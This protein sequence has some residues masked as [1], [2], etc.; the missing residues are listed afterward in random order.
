MKRVTAIITTIA[1]LAALTGCNNG[2]IPGGAPENSTGNSATESTD[3]SESAPESTDNSESAPESSVPEENKGE[4]TFLTCVDGT[5]VY[6][7]DV[8][9]LFSSLVDITPSE[10][11]VKD[12]S[13]EKL[14]NGDYGVVC[15]GFVYAFT[16]KTAFNRIQ[17]PDKFRLNEGDY[18]YV[19][20]ETAPS[21]EYYRVETGDKFG[22]LTVKKAW[23]TFRAN[24]SN[25]EGKDIDGAYT[26]AGGLEFDG[27]P[28]LTGYVPVSRANEGAKISFVPDNECVGKIPVVKYAVNEE[29][30]AVQHYPRETDGVT[31]GD[32]DA[33]L[34]DIIHDY[35]VD[36]DALEEGERFTHV[37]ITIGDIVSTGTAYISEINAKLLGIEKI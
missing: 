15:E 33:F 29:S 26:Y 22:E 16:P 9:K 34:L 17:N 31:Y 28:E 25:F 36:P 8:T 37:K 20:D 24:Y 13:A 27:E 32:I 21:S 3:S 1:M 14:I 19:G 30:A 6:T 2:E 18:E 10:L 5:V 12:L 11:D 35:D 7:S 4:P 23:T